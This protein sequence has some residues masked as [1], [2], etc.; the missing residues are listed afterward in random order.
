ML[1][2]VTKQAERELDQIFVYWARRTNLDIADRLI[3]SI[4][5][6]FVLLGDYPDVGRKCDEIASGVLRFL[7]GDYLIYYRKKRSII[8]ILHVFHVARD[9]GRA[10]KN[11]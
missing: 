4:E 6:R 11:N 1:F 9:Q 10:I 3:D 2:H 5:E 7:A 8:Q